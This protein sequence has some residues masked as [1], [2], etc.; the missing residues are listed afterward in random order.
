MDKSAAE[1]IVTATVRQKMSKAMDM[2]FYWI[3]D[4]VKQKD[5]FVYWK[6]EAKT[7][8]IISRNITHHITIGKFVLRICIWQIP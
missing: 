5:F 6:K 8:R 4:R 7:W 2:Q 3:K 1:G